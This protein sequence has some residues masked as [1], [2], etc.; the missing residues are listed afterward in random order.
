MDLPEVKSIV[1][2][3]RGEESGERH[4]WATC[5][6]GLLKGFQVIAKWNKF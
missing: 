2:V 5:T 3:T 6:E 4:A 1:V